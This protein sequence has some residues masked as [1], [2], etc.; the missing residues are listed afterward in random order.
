[1][2]Y[3]RKLYAPQCSKRARY[4]VLNRKNTV[5]GYACLRCGTK[6]VAALER[7]KE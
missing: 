3:L 1:M 5:I 6:E 7:E 2:A 4:E